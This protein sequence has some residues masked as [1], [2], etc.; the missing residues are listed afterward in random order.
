MIK[1]IFSEEIEKDL[2]TK[3]KNRQRKNR[4]QM[5]VSG[6]RLKDLQRLI[7]NKSNKIAP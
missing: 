6:R 3:L 2:E 1:T 5:K 4:P 7:I